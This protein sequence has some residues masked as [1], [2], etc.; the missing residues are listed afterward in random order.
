MD[1]LARTGETCLWQENHSPWHRRLRKLILEKST[2]TLYTKVYRKRRSR[3]ELANEL[4]SDY[5]LDL[6]GLLGLYPEFGSN[7]AGSSPW[8]IVTVLR[9]RWLAMS[10]LKNRV[11]L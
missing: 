4:C 10:P 5:F 11:T 1:R 8:L 2:K 7:M 6:F 9:N 3:K